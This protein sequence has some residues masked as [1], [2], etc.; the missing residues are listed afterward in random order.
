M[1]KLLSI[2]RKNN[3]AFYPINTNMGFSVGFQMVEV[4]LPFP[5]VSPN[6]GH[7]IT[8]EEKQLPKGYTFK[9]LSRYFMA[10]RNLRTAKTMGV[11]IINSRSHYNY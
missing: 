2:S 3:I 9:S 8:F 11:N 4:I 7:F 1:R 5:G 6:I 10:D